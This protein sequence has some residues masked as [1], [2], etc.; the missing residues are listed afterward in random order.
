[1]KNCRENEGN[2]NKSERLANIEFSAPEQI[3][4]SSHVT[5]A[6]D[7]YSLAQVLYWFIFNKVNRGTGGE[8]IASVF[9][10]EDAYIYDEI[11]YKCINN[12]PEE[13]FQSINEI[14]TY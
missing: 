11:I 1:M 2:L 10:D 12:N 8:Y 9:V 13:R 3:D 5:E 14:E 7:I 6:T 4:N